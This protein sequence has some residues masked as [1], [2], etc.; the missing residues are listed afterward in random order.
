MMKGRGT[1]PRFYAGYNEQGGE[2]KEE[3]KNTGHSSRTCASSYSFSAYV[4]A[5]QLDGEAPERGGALL[6]QLK[7][8]L[9]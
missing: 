4:G 7:P 9:V 6:A 3:E 2:K 5:V 8:Q 1:L